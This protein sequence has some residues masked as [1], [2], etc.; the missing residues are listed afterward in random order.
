[1]KTVVYADRAKPEEQADSYEAAF[2]RVRSLLAQPQTLESP[3]SLID[4]LQ[5]STILELNRDLRLLSIID[6]SG[7]AKSLHAELHTTLPVGELL[8]NEITR[9]L[10]PSLE[11]TLIGETQI[12]GVTLLNCC[13]LCKTTPSRDNTGVVSGVM[14]TLCDNSVF[15][16]AEGSE[17]QQILVLNAINAILQKALTCEALDGLARVFL[18][19]A[20][21]IT[22]CKMGFIGQLN[23]RNHLDNIAISDSGWA[24]CR[25]PRTKALRLVNEMPI[26]GI[27]GAVIRSGESLLCNEPDQHPDRVGTPEGHPPIQSFLGVPLKSGDQVMGLIALANKE[28]GFTD[29]DKTAIEELASAF[30][31]AMER[32]HL[33]EEDK[34]DRKRLEKSVQSQRRTIDIVSQELRVGAVKL[35]QS[36]EG[37]I[38]SEAFTRSLIETAGV[39]I[40]CLDPEANITL[41][42]RYAENLTGYARAEVIGKNWFDLFIAENEQ[43][44]IKGVFLDF[45]Q[46]QPVLHRYVNPIVIGDGTIRMISW[47]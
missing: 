42:N 25:I 45:L 7:L 30:V 33:E 38:G 16:A 22:N 32:K 15:Q 31:K 26:R 5:L 18:A 24:T 12:F 46:Q 17:I 43:D 6:Q 21:I 44:E 14:I 37:H 47:H 39:I 34:T 29:F 35:E 23:E 3:F 40:L 36:I 2:D 28:F 9:I 11:A 1:M 19:W 13:Y 20:Q 10:K 27:W 4:A 8:P 41:F